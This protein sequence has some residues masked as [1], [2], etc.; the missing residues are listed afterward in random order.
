M[1]VKI[2]ITLSEDVL[3]A[4]DAN[5][6]DYRSRSEFLEEAARDLLARR[7]RAEAEARDL[8][9]LNRRAKALNAEA[10]DVLAYQ[11]PR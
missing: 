5:L 10:E 2:S 7:A 6:E 11:V 9:I 8:E 4:I 3:T 1:K